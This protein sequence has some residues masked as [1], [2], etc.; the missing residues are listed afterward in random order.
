MRALPAAILCATLISCDPGLSIHQSSDGSREA[1]GAA[2]DGCALDI[3]I[4]TSQHLIGETWYFPELSITN[5]GK[6]SA[7]LTSIELLTEVRS[8]EAQDT[9]KLK[10]EIPANASNKISTLFEFGETPLYQV[11]SKPATLRV[12]YLSAGNSRACEVQ[13]VGDR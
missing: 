7:A 9:T 5:R 11:F 2:A 10:D 8:Y 4:A 3:R 12:Q 1:V 6:V 13:V